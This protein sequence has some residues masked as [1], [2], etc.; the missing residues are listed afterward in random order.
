MKLDL[1]SIVI[2]VL[3]ISVVGMMSSYFLFGDNH[4]REIKELEKKNQQIEKEK[5][6]IDIDLNRLKNEYKLKDVLIKNL[7]D[8]AQILKEK[9]LQKDLEIKKANNDLDKFKKELDKTRKQIQFLE[10]NPNYK[11]GDN[12]LN[13]L[14]EKT[15]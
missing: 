11:N 15:K 5:K 6:D 10:S 2:I 1:K 4:K 8:S 9:L 14:R 12:L 13:S 3:T 7:Q